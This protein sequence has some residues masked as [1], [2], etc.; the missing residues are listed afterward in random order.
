MAN[1]KDGPDGKPADVSI[2]ISVSGNETTGRDCKRD[3]R[4]AAFCRACSNCSCCRTELAANAE[5]G[6]T[7]S[8]KARPY[9][10]KENFI[11]PFTSV[12]YT[13]NTMFVF[14]NTQYINSI[15]C[16]ITA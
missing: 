16:N 10:E 15:N 7:A 3:S 11:E 8:T 5:K 4:N 2:P 6:S 13:M 14:Y 1:K 12:K 9:D